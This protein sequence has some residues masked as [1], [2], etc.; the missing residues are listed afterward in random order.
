MFQ[1]DYVKRQIEN[2]IHFLTK[3]LLKK[4]LVNYQLPPQG[5]PFSTVDCLYED[6]DRHLRNGEIN[7]AEN[8]LFDRAEP[9]NLQYLQLA[10]DFYAQL[11]DMEP[12]YLISCQYTPEEIQEGLEDIAQ[13]FGVVLPN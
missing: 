6:I 2:C 10:L 8:L 7:E 12:D 3:T 9:G 11:K 4:D 1:Q 13:M 5:E